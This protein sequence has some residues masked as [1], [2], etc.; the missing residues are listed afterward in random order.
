MGQ[1]VNAVNMEGMPSFVAQS[2]LH[3]YQRVNREEIRKED[4]MQRERRICLTVRK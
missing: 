4:G 3:L 1:R 2:G